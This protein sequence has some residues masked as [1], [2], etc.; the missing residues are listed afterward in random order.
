M[1][2]DANKTKIMIVSRSCTM[3]LQSHTL[4]LEWSEGIWWP[5][6][7]GTTF[8]VKM[9][10]EE[11]L[12]VFGAVAQRLGIMSKSWQ[13]FL[14]RSLM[15]IS[16]CS[17]VLPVL[18]YCFAVGLL[19]SNSHLKLLVQACQYCSDGST[20]KQNLMMDKHLGFHSCSCWATFLKSEIFNKF[21]Y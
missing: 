17:L 19:A 14:N 10:F 16:L 2:F 8:D 13:V 3:H 18:V 15:L 4:T 6:H 11:Q 9:I 20:M 5:G 12:S 1:M 7:I 21:Q